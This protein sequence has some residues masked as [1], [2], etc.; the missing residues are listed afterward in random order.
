MERINQKNIFKLNVENDVL[1][2]IVIPKNNY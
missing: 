1:G 2:F